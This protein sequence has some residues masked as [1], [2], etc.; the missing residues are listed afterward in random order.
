[1]SENWFPCVNCC[2][3]I[4]EEHGRWFYNKFFCMG[5]YKKIRLKRGDDK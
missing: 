5:C 3:V 4:L 2:R 1:M